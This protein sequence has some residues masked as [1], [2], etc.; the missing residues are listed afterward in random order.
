MHRAGLL[1]AAVLLLAPAACA[2]AGAGV[3]TWGG[4]TVL[5]SATAN[6]SPPAKDV[7]VGAIDASG[8]V[9]AMTTLAPELL[10]PQLPDSRGVA[11]YEAGRGTRP[12]LVE[13][14]GKPLAGWWGVLALSPDGKTLYFHWEASGEG[15]PPSPSASKAFVHDLGTG[16]TKA[17]EPAHDGHVL[18]P[19]MIGGIS[20]DGRTVAFLATTDGGPRGPHAYAWHDGAV[21]LLRSEAYG[22]D[23]SADGRW[24]ATG[25]LDGF[26]VHDLR[27]GGNTT[28]LARP[29]AQGEDSYP[30]VN[31]ALS[32]DG[33]LVAYEARVD[34]RQHVFVLDRATGE[35]QQVPAPAASERAAQ[36]Q[37][38]AGFSD[39]GRTL[40]FM[41]FGTH[42]DGRGSRWAVYAHDLPSGVSTLVD[43][44]SP[45]LL[46]RCVQPGADDSP[47]NDCHGWSQGLLSA[48]GST[49]AFSSGLPDLLAASANGTQVVVRTLREPSGAATSGT[50][51][52]SAPLGGPIPLVAL[53]ALAAWRAG[54]ARSG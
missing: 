8:R 17:W 5:A 38:L 48:D 25:G 52:H 34:G 9:V 44:A 29:A 22:V 36:M 21:Q 46:G 53:L 15:V 33:G 37:R 3:P 43:A 32:G 28:I 12:V 26:R 40:L 50:E 6:G 31:V 30:P 7:W 47:F 35:A 16:Q 18:E 49:V 4:A 42:G 39:D 19:R 2:Q 1:A 27:G 11:V 10:P 41:A 51:A 54:R 45:D 13:W 20:A 14:E 23:V 24:A